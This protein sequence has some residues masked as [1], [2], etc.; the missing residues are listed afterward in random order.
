MGFWD[1]ICIDYTCA[2]ECC[3]PKNE[4]K[5]ICYKCGMCGRKFDGQFMV[6]DGDT[7]VE[8]EYEDD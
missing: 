4:M 6:D 7:T 2:K 3:N 8:S 5:Y 1:N